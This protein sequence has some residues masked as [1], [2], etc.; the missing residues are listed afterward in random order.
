MHKF[1]VYDQLIREKQS[2]TV[3][4]LLDLCIDVIHENIDSLGLLQYIPEELLTRILSPLTP[5]QLEKIEKYNEVLT[6]FKYSF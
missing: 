3:P 6:W 5:E 2:T 1:N 4:R